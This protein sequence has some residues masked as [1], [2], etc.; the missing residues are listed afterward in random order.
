L[1]FHISKAAGQ[2]FEAPASVFALGDD[3]PNYY[4]F[5]CYL[6]KIYSKQIIDIC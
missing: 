6:I 1:A 2:D 4:K 3:S 5:A